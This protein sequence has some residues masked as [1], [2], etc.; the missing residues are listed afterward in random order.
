VK[1]L[2][3]ATAIATVTLTSGAA[4]FKTATLVSGNHSMT[5]QYLGDALNAPS[6]STVLVQRVNP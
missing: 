1:L 5:A 3:G 6:T 4:I 2:D